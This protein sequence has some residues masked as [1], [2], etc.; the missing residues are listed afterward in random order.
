MRGTL[1]TAISPLQP[2]LDSYWLAVHVLAAIIATGGFTVATALTALHLHRS[3]DATAREHPRS[4]TLG[5]VAARLPSGIAL[6][7]LARQTITFA[8]PV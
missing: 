4:P 5:A 7:R 1:Y 6:E 3:R 2:S 8:F